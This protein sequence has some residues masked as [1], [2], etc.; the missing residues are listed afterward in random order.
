MVHPEHVILHA[1]VAR[2]L[3]RVMYEFCWSAHSCSEVVFM[4]WIGE[5]WW[6]FSTRVG[7]LA[8]PE[9]NPVRARRVLVSVHDG[10]KH[11]YFHP[12]GFGSVKELN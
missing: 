8:I 5:Q 3:F 1:T 10:Y 9:R 12:V 2:S 6:M 7:W 4:L 11:V